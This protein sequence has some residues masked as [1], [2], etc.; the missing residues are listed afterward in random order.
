ME[1]RND[2]YFGS[3]IDW[4]FVRNCDIYRGKRFVEEM[5]DERKTD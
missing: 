3:G 5:T 2:E 4:A 1:E